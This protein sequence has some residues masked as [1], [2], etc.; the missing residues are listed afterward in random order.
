VLSH[1]L[2]KT[3]LSL[4]FLA[5]TLFL[6]SAASADVPP[7]NEAQCQTK[8]V[9]DS[10]TTD[11]GK[12]GACATSTCTRLDYS[13]GSP[14]GTEEYECKLCDE[15]APQTGE[16][17]SESGGGCSIGAGDVGSGLALMGLALPLLTFLRRR[18]SS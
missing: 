5:S 7:P 10:C 11:D 8:K 4:G 14:P 18:R 9:G 12:S 17:S 13:Q 1:L 3:L 16:E 15:S 2:M 6:A